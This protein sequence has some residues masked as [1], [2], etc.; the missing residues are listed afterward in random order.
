MAVVSMIVVISSIV[1]LLLDDSLSDC[2]V[3]L[4]SSVNWSDE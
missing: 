1:L 3:V 4:A 2:L